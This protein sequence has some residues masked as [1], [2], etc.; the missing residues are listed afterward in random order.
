[1]SKNNNIRNLYP[2]LFLIITIIT[3][4][5]KISSDP[6][7]P[8]SRLNF[9][10]LPVENLV[11]KEFQQLNNKE[12][13]MESLRSYRDIR[14]EP[15]TALTESILEKY[16]KLNPNFLAETIFIL[17]VVAGQEQKILVEI[18]NFLQS[19]QN[20]QDIPY[21][22]EY[23]KTTNPL[24]KEIVLKDRLYYQDGS[25]EI[26]TRQIMTPFNIY[27]AVNRYKL[28]QGSL[29]YETFNQTPLNYKWM[30]GVDE[31]E[32]YTTL[33]VQAYPGYLFFYGLGGARAFDFFGLFG[34]RLDAAFIG[35]SEA[36]FEWFYNDF[37]LPRW[38]E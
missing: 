37:V 6:V 7:L 14:L 28:T 5:V 36:F 26:I 19:V 23:N 18:R 16:S 1:M 30:K 12:I 20:F 4:P 10:Q 27:T 11:Q 32:M 2:I 33:L 9:F 3:N 8:L 24:F 25:L 29:L 38:V 21:Y 22:S 15:D 31:E 35:R 34:S 17:P 13:V